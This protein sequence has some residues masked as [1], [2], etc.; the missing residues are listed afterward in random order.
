[1]N[2]PDEKFT[3]FLEI[4][5][6]RYQEFVLEIDQY[7]I[8]NNC[9][10][11]LKPAKN[12]YIASYAFVDSK[13]ALASF[14]F[15]KSG[16]KLRIYPEHIAQYDVFL[17]TLPEKMKKEI[18]K[19]SICKRLVNPEDCNPKC[20]M[21]YEFHMDSE[22]YQKCRYMAFMPTLNEENNPYIKSFLEQEL[23]AWNEKES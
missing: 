22:Q 18:K 20:I 6:E 11:V 17:N 10:R 2:K 8:Q 7:L 5:E 1:M 21:G 12:G 9:K 13:R 16:I 14:V 15:R 4:V 19:A 3:A 23:K